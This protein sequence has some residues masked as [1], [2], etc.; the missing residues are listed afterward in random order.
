[1]ASLTEDGEKYAEYLTHLQDLLEANKISYVANRKF[2]RV[3][4]TQNMSQ[5]S[6]DH[7]EEI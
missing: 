6:P 2:P 7:I 1:M 4:E 5:V 3:R